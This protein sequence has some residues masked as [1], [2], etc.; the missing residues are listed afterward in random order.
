LPARVTASLALLSVLTELFVAAG[1]WYRVTRPAAFAAGVA[2][3][4]TI[5]ATLE[6]T[7]PLI[8][9]ALLCVSCYPLFAVTVGPAPGSEAAQTL[10]RNSTTSPSAIT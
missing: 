5:V 1:T 7:V 2:L 8:A 9:F 3:H 10:K 4:L 6:P